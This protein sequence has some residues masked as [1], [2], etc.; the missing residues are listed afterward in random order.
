LYKKVA[1]AKH[2]AS[3]VTHLTPA[4]YWNL[5]QPYNRLKELRSDHQD[6]SELTVPITNPIA[7]ERIKVSRECRQRAQLFTAK[8]QALERLR[9][10]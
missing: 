4:E 6:D 9:Q 8:K 3:S 10:T 2:A 7:A 1:A 5:P